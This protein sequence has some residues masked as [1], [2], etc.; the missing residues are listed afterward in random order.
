M[1]F[2]DVN[3][4]CL[5][6]FQQKFRSRIVSKFRIECKEAFGNFQKN[7]CGRDESFSDALRKFR[8]LG[9]VQGT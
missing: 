8:I 2:E 4:G 6:M 9:R 5:E 3:R 7:C 1:F